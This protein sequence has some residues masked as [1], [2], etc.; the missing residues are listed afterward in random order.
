[1]EFEIENGNQATIDYTS[2]PVGLRSPNG[3][4]MRERRPSL[5]RKFLARSDSPN[6]AT[7]ARFAG[8]TVG[9]TA[10]QSDLAIDC[11]RRFE[12]K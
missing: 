2:R 8:E 12:R 11:S 3:D 7:F 10:D 1:M 9:T 4:R 6:G 5:T